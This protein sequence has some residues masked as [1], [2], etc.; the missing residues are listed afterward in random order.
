MSG[1]DV[2]INGIGSL[3]G[4]EG[5]SNG[6]VWGCEG[7]PLMAHGRISPMAHGRLM[8]SNYRG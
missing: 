2:R 5:D 4:D 3:E 1:E 7:A 8:T 6:G